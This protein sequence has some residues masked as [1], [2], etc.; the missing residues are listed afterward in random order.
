[1]TVRPSGARL[2]RDRRMALP[3][4]TVSTEEE[5]DDLCVLLGKLGYDGIYRLT[6]FS[7]EFE[8]IDKATVTLHEAYQN[9]KAIKTMDAIGK[10]TKEE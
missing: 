4:Y 10:P 5:G 3:I 2:P 1:M 7:G 8:D 6:N 9:I